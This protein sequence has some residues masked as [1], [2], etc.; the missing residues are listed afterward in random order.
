[1][2]ERVRRKTPA[3]P[4]FL[5]KKPEPDRAKRRATILVVDDVPDIRELMRDILSDENNIVTA[6]DCESAIEVLKDLRVDL[7]LSDLRMREDDGGMT[8]LRWVKENRPETR[9]ILV[10][11]D[12]GESEKLEA[13][14]LGADRIIKKPYEVKEFE[15]S[16][17]EVLGASGCGSR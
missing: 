14:R 10:S 4:C 9:F 16:V 6:V 3:V 13:M 1:M 7:I 5:M 11:A 8:L 15:R 2:R 12:A 17:S